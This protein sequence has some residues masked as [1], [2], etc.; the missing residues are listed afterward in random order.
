MLMRVIFLIRNWSGIMFSPLLV[1]PTNKLA[2]DTK[3]RE[4]EYVKDNI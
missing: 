1:L 2:L 4:R 3:C